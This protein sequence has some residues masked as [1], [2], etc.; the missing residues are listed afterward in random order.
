MAPSDDP[1]RA[2][3]HTG[4]FC[5]SINMN[6]LKL[7]AYHNNPSNPAFPND[8]FYLYGDKG[9][10]ISLFGKD[11]FLDMKKITNQSADKAG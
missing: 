10:F 11:S 7:Y 4:C 6:R 8:L 2:L 5:D 1:I 3:I 9:R